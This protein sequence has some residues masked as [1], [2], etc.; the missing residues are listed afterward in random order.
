MSRTSIETAGGPRRVS[1]NGPTM[2]S[3]WTAVWYDDGRPD[4]ME[5]GRRLVAAVGAVDDQMSTWKQDSALMRLNRAPVRDWQDVPTNLAAVLATA[6]E[7]GR[8]TG[9]AF[10]VGVGRLVADWG[11]GSHA[12]RPGALAGSGSSLPVD[13]LE[14]DHGRRRVRKHAPMALDLSGIAKGFGV[15]ELARV[16][17]DAEIGCFLV[18]IDGEMRARGRKPDGDAMVRRDRKAG[19][20][21]PCRP[22]DRPPRGPGGRDLRRLPPVPRRSGRPDL[23]YDRPAHRQPR[24]ERR[25]FRHGDGPDRHGRRRAR[26]GADGARSRR[27]RRPREAGGRRRPLHPPPGRRFLRRDLNRAVA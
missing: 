12:G 1:L 13:A 22:R 11:F 3:R 14:V 10:D 20:H 27:R 25:R 5:I 16:L 7:I 21:G 26:H 4:A 2:G 8:A 17:D 23:P 18:G 15:D 9:G 19:R 24:A 6:L